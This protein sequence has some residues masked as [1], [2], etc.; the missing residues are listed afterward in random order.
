MEVQHSDIIQAPCKKVYAL[1][2]DDLPEIA[3]Y[4]PNIKKIKKI[5]HLQT[6]NEHQIVNQWF[7]ETKIPTIISTIISQDLFSWKDDAKWDDKRMLVN[8]NIESFINK[9]IFEAK[10][11]NTFEEHSLNSTKL[12]VSCSVKINA[13]K[14]PGVPFLLSRKIS[15]IIEK[16]IESLLAPNLTYLSKGIKKH[17]A[18]LK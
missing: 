6:K 10:G 11:I 14:V 9:D 17:L 13:K 1:V 5:R 18:D 12:T 8:Y 2:R 7:A 4:F 3:Q 16:L 15:P